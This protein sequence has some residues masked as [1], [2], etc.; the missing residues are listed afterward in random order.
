MGWLDDVAHVIVGTRCVACENAALGVC[1]D[2]AAAL[3][4]RARIVRD[5]PCPVAAAGDYDG[6]LRSALIAWKERG[7]FTVE[8]PL[9]H[10]LAASGRSPSGCSA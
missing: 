6:V 1:R 4:P 3:R 2:C 10:L 8:R 9:A 7:R 5:R